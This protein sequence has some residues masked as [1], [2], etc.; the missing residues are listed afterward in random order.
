MAGVF[1][2]TRIRAAIGLI[3]AYTIA[4]QT[5]FAAFAPLPGG[6]NAVMLR[7]KHLNL[8]TGPHP[9]AFKCLR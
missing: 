1:P 2:R 4:L 5:L 9:S 3:A 6:S 7:G 8:K